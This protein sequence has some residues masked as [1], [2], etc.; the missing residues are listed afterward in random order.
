MRCWCSYEH[1]Q[2]EPPLDSDDDTVSV[3]MSAI[4]TYY[5]PVIRFSAIQK[6]QVHLD[7]QH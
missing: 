5:I 1:V 6:M 4:K 7:V 3:R 2:S